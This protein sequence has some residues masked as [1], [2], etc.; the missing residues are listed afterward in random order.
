MDGRVGQACPAPSHMLQKEG[1]E[2]PADRTGKA[3][4]QGQCGDRRPGRLPVIAAEGGERRVIEASPHAK[5]ED[6]PADDEHPQGGGRCKDDEA[7][8]E[9]KAGQ[10]QNRAPTILTDGIADA[11]RDYACRKQADGQ[12]ADNPRQRPPGISCNRRGKDREQ[13]VRTAPC[14]NLDDAER[15]KHLP[16]RPDKRLICRRFNCHVS[17]FCLDRNGMAFAFIPAL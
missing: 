2:R 16:A 3:A 1:R 17:V 5:A 9:Q 15:R 8:G 14:E 11:W 4:P 13:V 7:G 6:C 10:R 12:R